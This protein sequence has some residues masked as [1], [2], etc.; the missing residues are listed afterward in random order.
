MKEEQK[1][2]LNSLK[3]I[4]DEFKAGNEKGEKEEVDESDFDDSSKDPDWKDGFSSSGRRSEA[5]VT[6]R[7]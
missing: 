1:T 5:R 6:A 3:V 2:K 4:M 7:A